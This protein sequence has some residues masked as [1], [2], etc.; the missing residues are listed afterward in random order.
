[1]KCGKDKCKK[2]AVGYVATKTN[3]GIIIFEARCK[4]HLYA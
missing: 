2:E 1:M 3:K 4:E